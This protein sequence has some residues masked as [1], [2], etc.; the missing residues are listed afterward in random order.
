MGA[1][2]MATGCQRILLVD[3][4]E[5]L[6]SVY[7]RMLGKTCELVN[8]SAGIEAAARLAKDNNFDAIVCEVS[9][10]DGDG[11]FLYEWLRQRRPHLLPRFIFL[12][13]GLFDV[14]I[15]RLVRSSGI[16]C[17]EKPFTKAQFRQQIVEVSRARLSA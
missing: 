3:D 6:L 5:N 16:P 17:L 9:L 13:A 10:K 4:E 12:T 7:R 2:E 1:S 14:R 11:L 8:C 15:R